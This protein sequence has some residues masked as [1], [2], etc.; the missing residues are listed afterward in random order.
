[1]DYGRTM[2]VITLSALHF[3]HFMKQELSDCPV[4]AIRMAVSFLYRYVDINFKIL[5]C[6]VKWR[7]V[8]VD[9]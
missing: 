6:T 4:D 5:K 2:Y 7:L 3:H 9:F 1:M 8:D